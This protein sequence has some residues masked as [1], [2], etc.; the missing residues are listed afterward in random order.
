MIGRKLFFSAEII[1]AVVLANSFVFAFA[2][3]MPSLPQDDGGN[4]VLYILP[5]ETSSM[6]FVVQ[7]GGGATSP[8]NA[9]VDIV[10]GT[11]YVQLVDANN[12]YAIDAGGRV[13]VNVRVSVPSTAQLGESHDVALAFS[14][15]PASSGGFAFGSA[16]QQR[17][18]IVI[19]EEPEEVEE[20]VSAPEVP[21]S[22][23]FNKVLIGIL[24]ILILVV[25]FII[26]RHLKK[27]NS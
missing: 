2:V 6:T 23:L 21:K 22:Q 3:S 17:F 9:K 8:I 27:K 5:G 14:T 15:A 20:N 11:D 19:G 18:K 24:I 7:N 12:I 4:R 16:V 26:I 10:D 25:L 13:D 1:L